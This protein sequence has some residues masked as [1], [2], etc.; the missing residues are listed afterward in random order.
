[1]T[2]FDHLQIRW[3]CC[4][5]TFKD[6][7]GC[8]GH[9][10]QQGGIPTDL[11][12]PFNASGHSLAELLLYSCTICGFT[13][14]AE[15]SRWRRAVSKGLREV[16]LDRIKRQ[17]GDREPPNDAVPGHSK[18]ERYAEIRQFQNAGDFEIAEYD[19]RASWAVNASRCR[20]LA[21]RHIE[22]ALA[23]NSALFPEERVL[24]EYLAGEMARRLD[25]WSSASQHYSCA[26]KIAGG[27]PVQGILNELA[28]K[29]STDPVDQSN[30]TV[31]N[32]ALDP[33]S[34][35]KNEPVLW[36]AKQLESREPKAALERYMRVYQRCRAALDRFVSF[37]VPSWISKAKAESNSASTKFVQQIA[38]TRS[39][40]W[41]DDYDIYFGSQAL[42]HIV[43]LV[44]HA[45]A[46]DREWI[47]EDS[48]RVLVRVHGPKASVHLRGHPI[49]S[50]A[51]QIGYRT[52]ID[53]PNLN[54][55]AD[56]S[57]L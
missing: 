56:V 18:F 22:K 55:N 42:E 38:R 26:T 37:D 44:H 28:R 12:S 17:F 5:G 30:W 24:A 39:G 19:V 8:I 35:A 47:M 46:A 48:V 52:E 21:L 7:Y 15:L 45:E 13:E 33:L 40:F 25:L 23:S 11:R 10:S 4:H 49:P 32:V 14:R 3:P 51:P 20:A 27:S 34:I 41:V 9:V 50:R 57:A 6:E 1:M 16:V 54:I 53:H 29:Q 43:G 31:K 36:A 2:W